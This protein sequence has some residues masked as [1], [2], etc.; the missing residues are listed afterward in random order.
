MAVPC[1]PISEPLFPGC[2]A[3]VIGP[4]IAQYQPVSMQQMKGKGKK[5][6]SQSQY[7]ETG[8]KGGKKLKR[9]SS[10]GAIVTQEWDGQDL[11]QSEPFKNIIEPL[12][13]SIEDSQGDQS[14]MA[15][16]NAPN[17]EPPFPEC[18]SD[19]VPDT[20]QYQLNSLPSPHHCFG[21]TEDSIID[22]IN[23]V[24]E[25]DRVPLLLEQERV[26]LLLEQERVPLL[27]EQKTLAYGS[28]NHSL[29]QLGNNP[30]LKNC[31]FG[32][33]SPEHISAFSSV[34]DPD[35]G[36][37]IPQDGIPTTVLDDASIL[38]LEEP[39]EILLL[40]DC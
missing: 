27:L 37:I 33:S 10:K 19:V 6:L 4:E 31:S 29:Y 32:I 8:V 21:I 7:K 5:R 20:A 9:I 40:F 16:I 36:N 25:T 28:T 17:S 3:D 22:S 1:A 39:S 12:G 34:N 11:Q 38:S 24:S 18:L 15:I 30:I 26:P 2:L 13:S 35:H 14:N 23:Q